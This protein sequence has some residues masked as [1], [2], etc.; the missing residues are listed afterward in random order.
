MRIS[1]PLPAYCFTHSVTS[2]TKHLACLGGFVLR[3]V[4][5]DVEAA[6]FFFFFEGLVDRVLD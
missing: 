2:S 1:S 5:F 6:A 3:A 4:P